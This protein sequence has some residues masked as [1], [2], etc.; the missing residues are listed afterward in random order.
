[1]KLLRTLWCIITVT[2][3]FILGISI[4]DKKYLSE[5]VL[6]IWV[7]ADDQTQIQQVSDYILQLQCEDAE[8]LYQQVNNCGLSADVQILYTYF[9]A[10]MDGSCCIPAGVYT[11][12]RIIFDGHNAA[13]NKY[14]K[15]I[16]PLEIPF[17]P[18]EIPG[19]A[20]IQ[21][22]YIGFL[23]GIGMAEKLIRDITEF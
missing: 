12:I 17:E 5:S 21:K 2:F 22:H 1:M 6:G 23:S 18:I 14:F 9:D 20:F 3:F 15:Q 16:K 7:I 8:D 13:E 19:A 11:T 4:A 10:S